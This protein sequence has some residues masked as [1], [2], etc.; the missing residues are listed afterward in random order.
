MKIIRDFVE[1][2]GIRR[3]GAMAWLAR[4]I[5]V[6]QT[7]IRRYFDG[8]STPCDVRQRKIARVIGKKDARVTDSHRAGWE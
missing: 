5:N 7:T 1:P 6:S 2:G 3:R 8:K 4:E